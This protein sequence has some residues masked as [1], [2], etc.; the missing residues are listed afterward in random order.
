MSMS[1]KDFIALAQVIDD[2]NIHCGDGEGEF[3]QEQIEAIADFCKEQ[4]SSFMRERWMGYISG[5]CGK[6]GGKVGAR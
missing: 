6:S 2:F 4:N 5:T 3:S 1:K